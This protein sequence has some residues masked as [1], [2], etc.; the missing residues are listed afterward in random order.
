MIRRREKQIVCGCLHSQWKPRSVMTERY[1]ASPS[2]FLPLPPSPVSGS[3]SSPPEPD[4]FSRTIIAVPPIDKVTPAALPS[5][6]VAPKRKLSERSDDE[7]RKVTF[8]EVQEPI[9]S[10]STT[11][12]TSSSSSSSATSSSSAPSNNVVATFSPDQRRSALRKH[13]QEENQSKG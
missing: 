4:G 1:T 10:K 7:G 13:S 9:D 3:S 2:Q 5:N 11:R 12:R 8:K 6:P